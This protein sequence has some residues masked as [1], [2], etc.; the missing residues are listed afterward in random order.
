MARDPSQWI[1]DFGDTAALMLTVASPASPALELE[2]RARGVRDAIERQRRGAESG[3]VERALLLSHLGLARAGRAAV[4]AVRR[5]CSGRGSGGTSV[6]LSIGSCS[7]LDFA[8]T[9]S[10]AQ[11]REFGRR[12]IERRLQVHDF[13]PDAWGPVLVRD[14]A[15]TKDRLAEVATDRYSYRQLDDF[16]DLIQRTLQRVPVVAKV[17]RVAVL[18]EQ[19][20]MDYS[21]ERLAAFDLQASKIKD[22]LSARNMTAPGGIVETGT[23]NVRIDATAEFKSLQE[24]GDVLI[25]ASPK[26]VP[27]YLRDMVQI[28]RGYQTPTRYLNYLTSRD[29]S[30]DGAATARS[31]SPCRCD[32]ASRSC[33]SARP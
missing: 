3:R 17:Q 13:H 24:I 33:T 21:H 32:R 25:G 16:T 23:K 29:D 8:T 27:V 19:I 6:P 7:G 11:I 22:V 10:D 15:S 12:F 28:S 30:A 20:Y 14:P 1:S 9:R 18:P 5:R 31:R 4:H 2:L 26:G